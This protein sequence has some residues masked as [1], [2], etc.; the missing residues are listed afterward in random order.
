[1]DLVWHCAAV[2]LVTIWREINCRDRA[3]GRI[4]RPVAKGWR[5][6]YSAGG[7]CCGLSAASTAHGRPVRSAQTAVYDRSEPTRRRPRPSR[8]ADLATS[9]PLDRVACRVAVITVA[10]ECGS[11]RTG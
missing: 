10:F 4:P 3:I 5:A 2:A 9:T 7:G 8:I 6:G 1:M 11:S